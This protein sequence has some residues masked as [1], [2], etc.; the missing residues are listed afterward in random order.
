M[1]PNDAAPVNISISN[2]PIKV[3][4]GRLEANVLHAGVGHGR[5]AASAGPL[6]LLGLHMT[7]SCDRRLLS[8]TRQPNVHWMLKNSSGSLVI[9]SLD[10]KVKQIRSRVPVQ[11]KDL[12]RW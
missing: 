5:Y 6:V 1:D 4:A 7:A 3:Q 11:Y 10:R 8:S 2:L 12:G 9:F